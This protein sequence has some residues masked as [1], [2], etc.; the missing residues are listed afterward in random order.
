MLIWSILE[1]VLFI[2][3]KSVILLKI[4]G[5]DSLKCINSLVKIL[6]N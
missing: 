4:L 1:K 3:S 6:N 5:I 2:G